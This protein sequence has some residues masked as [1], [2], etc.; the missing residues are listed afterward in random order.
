LHSQQVIEHWIQLYNCLT[1][2]SYRVTTRPC[3]E[4]SETDAGVVCADRGGNLIALE[5]ALVGIR[6]EEPG[7]RC[8]TIRNKLE[9]KLL[10]L[11]AANADKR[12]LLLESDSVA[13][14]IDERYAC[15]RDEASVKSSRSDVDEVWG[16]LTA[17]LDSENVIFTNRID[18][19]DDD[20]C[21]LCSHN[22]ITG[23]FWRLH[24]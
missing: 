10:K 12:I 17:I 23:E 7:A 8:L 24:G 5:H 9:R 18:P 19:A 1:G 3:T 14:S 20:D 22:V 2:G 11:S 15:V 13:G 16:A 6:N 21:S 4:P